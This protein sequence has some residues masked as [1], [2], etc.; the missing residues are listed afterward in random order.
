MEK[1]Q[2]DHLSRPILAL[3]EDRLHTFLLVDD[4]IRGAVIGG[5]RMINQMRWNHEL[6]ILETLVLGHAYLGA[7]LMSA[8]LKGR[9]RLRLQV[10]CSGPIKGLVV[11]ASAAGDIRGFL[12][13]VPIPVEKPL[14]DSNLSPF[15]G[16][17]FLSVTRMLEDAKQP[18]TGQVMIAHGNLAKDLAHYYLTSEQIPTAFSLSVKFDRQ[19]QVTAAGGMVLQALPEADDAVVGQLEDRVVS[20][21]SI[22]TALTEGKTPQEWVST[23]LRA[24]SPRFIDRRPVGFNCHC[25]RDQIRNL[26]TLMP[27][28]ELKDIQEKGPFPVIIRCHHCNTAYAFDREQID[29]IVAMRFSD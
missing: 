2:P 17:G 18:F 19:G 24:F 22:G 21:P 27:V 23:H 8:T 5:S 7:C 3:G 10:D 1:K 28:D 16:A 26:L 13:N 29:R 20:L 6:G 11:E 15:F 14:E 12:K 25:N 9:D 4:S